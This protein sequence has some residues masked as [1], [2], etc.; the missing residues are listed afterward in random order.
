[1]PIHKQSFKGNLLIQFDVEF[2]NPD[3]IDEPKK[4]KLKDILPK[5]APLKAPSGDVDEVTTSDY[6]PNSRRPG[7]SGTRRHDEMETDEEEDDGR[8]RQTQAQCMHC[9]M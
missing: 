6:Q 9:I 1:M 8:P 2:P 4:A 3:Q 7:T 5:S